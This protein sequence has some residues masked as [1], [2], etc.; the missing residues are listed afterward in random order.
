[1]IVH[2]CFFQMRELAEGS[3]VYVFPH[4][5]VD[6]R[7]LK[8]GESAARHLL[9]VFYTTPQI[10]AAGNLTGANHKGGISAVI[11]KAMN[12]MFLCCF[13]AALD[14]LVCL[15]EDVNSLCKRYPA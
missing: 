2:C 8:S 4:T 1:M 13:C 6:L 14:E 7:K 11:V 12:G 9:S 3:G 5:L 15:K 10:V